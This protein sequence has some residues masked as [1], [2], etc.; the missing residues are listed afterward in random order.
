MNFLS[1]DEIGLLFGPL[2]LVLNSLWGVVGWVE[3]G[4]DRFLFLLQAF[5]LLNELFHDLDL[6][7]VAHF[8]SF[9]LQFHFFDPLKVD[10]SFVKFGGFLLRDTPS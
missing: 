9:S 7:E 3:N 6:L 5:L 1:L 4:I 2:V 8:F 10:F